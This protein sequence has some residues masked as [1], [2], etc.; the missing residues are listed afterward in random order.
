MGEGNPSD[1]GKLV[2]LWTTGDVETAE[3][4]VFMYAINSKTRGWWDNVLL[5]V[6]GAAQKA[7]C[8]HEALQEEL[9]RA[10]KAGVEVQACI[11]C[12]ELY[13]LTD[14]L[15]EMGVEVISMGPPL[16]DMLKKRMH[17]LSV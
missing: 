17:I 13:G 11:A 1:E 6:W 12:A 2:L 10:M 3:R 14:R 7:L 16:T 8:G 5:V 4:M 15:R 9:L